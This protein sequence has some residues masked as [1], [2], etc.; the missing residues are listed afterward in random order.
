MDN[1]EITSHAKGECN[2]KIE[3]V[4]SRKGAGGAATRYDV[5]GP[6]KQMGG[7]GL[8]PSFGLNMKFQDGPLAEGI[9]GLTNEVL[10][11]IL[12]DRLVGFQSGPF[13]CEANAFALAHVR[14]ALEILHARTAERSG[15]GVEGKHEA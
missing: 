15:R 2:S 14:E 7:A 8:V 4:A 13:A 10:L 3:V 6:R 9:N 5:F 11:A 12:E 1:R